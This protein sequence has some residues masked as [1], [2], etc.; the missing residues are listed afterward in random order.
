VVCAS[1]VS[2]SAARVRNRVRVIVLATVLR[3]IA[4]RRVDVSRRCARSATAAPVTSAPTSPGCRYPAAVAPDSS[5]GPA[6][7]G[8]AAAEVASDGVMQTGTPPSAST[9]PG[10]R[11]RSTPR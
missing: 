5:A 7:S 10:S 1:T 8:M 3:D 9:I 6:S 11:A 4:A 2:A